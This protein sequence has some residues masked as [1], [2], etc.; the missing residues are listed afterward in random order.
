MSETAT[1]NELSAKLRA[2]DDEEL[3]F[4]DQTPLF[5]AAADMLEALATENAR[6][7]REDEAFKNTAKAFIEGLGG[8]L[9]AANAAL[10]TMTAE[11]DAT[12]VALSGWKLVPITPT[13]DM[14][15]AGILRPQRDTEDPR[16]HEWG[17]MYRAIYGAMLEASPPADRVVTALAQIDR[18]LGQ[19]ET[20]VPGAS[21]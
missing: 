2:L 13:Q 11:R 18:A 12:L 4:T 5:T 16:D 7:K 17:G 8:R 14:L 6:L 1:P 19:G 21:S 20:A 3:C 10:A 15:M 9:V